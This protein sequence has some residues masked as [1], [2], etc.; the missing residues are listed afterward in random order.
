MHPSSLAFVGLCLAL[1]SACSSGRGASPVVTPPQLVEIPT[2]LPV[3]VDCRRLQTI[4][5]PRGSSAEDVIEAQQAALL[6][7]EEQIKACAR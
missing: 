1:L 3:S 6:R 2:P 4:R 5:Y 7:Y